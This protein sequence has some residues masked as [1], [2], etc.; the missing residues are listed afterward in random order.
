MQLWLC[1]QLLNLDVLTIAVIICAC[2]VC[3]IDMPDHLL[4][5]GIDNCK[6]NGSSLQVQ[7]YF[8]QLDKVNLVVKLCTIICVTR[9]L[10][11]MPETMHVSS[12]LLNCN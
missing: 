10:A 2:S 12:F 11:G 9:N 8:C 7:V 5:R 4:I 6:A 1:S 3:T